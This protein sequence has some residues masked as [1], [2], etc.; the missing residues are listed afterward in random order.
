VPST[1]WLTS[2]KEPAINA[3]PRR[4]TILAK[5]D[6]PS[7]LAQ[8]ITTTDVDGRS[9]G[10][11][12]YHDVSSRSGFSIIKSVRYPASRPGA[13]TVAGVAAGGAQPS[14]AQDRLHGRLDHDVCRRQYGSRDLVQERLEQVIIVVVDHGDIDG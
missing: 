10:F 2:N 7:V 14:P 8:E 1:L 6:G 11:A 13:M 5:F 9:D 4:Q 12:R 3:S